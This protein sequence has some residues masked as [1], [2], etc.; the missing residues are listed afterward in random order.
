MEMRQTI[1][2]PFDRVGHHGLAEIPL[3]LE[4]FIYVRDATTQEPQTPT[5]FAPFDRHYRV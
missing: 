5:T 4:S 3:S 2:A 1:D